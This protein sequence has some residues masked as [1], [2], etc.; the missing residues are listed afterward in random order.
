[1]QQIYL[2]LLQKNKNN[3]FS[4]FS[5][6]IEIDFDNVIALCQKI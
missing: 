5:K 2:K 3:N 4:N 1:M 6:E